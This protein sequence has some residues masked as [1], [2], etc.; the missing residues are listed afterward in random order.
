[1]PRKPPSPTRAR[2]S[3][4]PY[5]LT[6]PMRRG[7]SPRF[8]E[9]SEYD[10]QDLCCDLFELEPGIASCEVYGKRGETQRG[11]DLLAR[12][13]TGGGTELGQCKCPH[14]F[15]PPH[16]PTPTPPLLPPLA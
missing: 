5:H 13:S 7:I 14:P 12:T 4:K 15:P 16:I 9:M 1:M 8:F 6:P 2:G 3:S 10:F 11:V